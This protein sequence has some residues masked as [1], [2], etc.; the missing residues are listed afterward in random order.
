MIDKNIPSR[1]LKPAVNLKKISRKKMFIE[2][3]NKNA[4]GYCQPNK[5]SICY[6]LPL[7]SHDEDHFHHPQILK[8]ASSTHTQGILNRDKKNN[9]VYQKT[10]KKLLQRQNINNQINSRL[11]P[12]TFR[13]FRTQKPSKQKLRRNRN[14]CFNSKLYNKKRN[15]QKTTTTPKRTISNI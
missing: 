14:V 13:T 8:L 4:Q 5:D 3:K 11:T 2:N 12:A 1:F 7:H 9:E 15:F 6:N 10:T